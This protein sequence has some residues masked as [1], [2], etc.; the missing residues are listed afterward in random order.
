MSAPILVI[1]FGT[2]TSAASVVE[3]DDAWLVAEPASGGYLWP[4]AVCWDG[5]QLLVGTLADRRK[6]TDPTT[7]W[8][9]FKRGLAVDTP[10][11]LGHRWFRP[12]EL[13]VTVLSALKA[14]AQRQLGGTIDR[15]VLTVP[16][17]YVNGDPRRA[18]MAAAAEAA[19]FVA[20][21]LVPEPAA[22]A[23]AS[24]SG[25]HGGELVLVY[26]LG[27]GTF[28]A[29]L[30]RL[31]ETW[32]E[33]LGHA[34]LDDCGGRDI[35]ALLSSRIRHE[36]DQWLT[37]LR[38]TMAATPSAP[39]ALRLSMAIAD[40]AQRIKHQLTDVPVAQD[41]LMPNT[42][43]YQLARPE[44]AHMTAPHI[45]RTIACCTDLLA[46]L[47]VPLGDVSSVV[48]AGG[49]SRMPV[50][51]ERLERDLG[52][53]LRRIPEPDLAVVRGAA[54]WLQRSGSRVVQA[55]RIPARTVPLAF[56]IPG[57]SARLLRWHVLPGETYAEG[58]RLARVRL[59][60][61]AL[62]DLTAAAPG[63]ID[64]FLVQPGRD[65]GATD[66]LALARH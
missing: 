11:L 30:V 41:F 16:A 37:P 10:I 47:G 50:I 38:N 48:L 3:D 32:H 53:P 26:D 1:D 19:G 28:D 44:F 58:S 13:V 59:P 33:V 42:P 55:A 61:G 25:Q 46:R 18:R 4:S 49:S 34:A 52:R 29:A 62:W 14:E 36:S 51:A 54:R 35:D 43:M 6:R 23:F 20:V 31:G 15:A 5:Q 45:G 63:M 8:A 56:P 22:A 66:W 57:G 39:A 17:S 2:T 64:R 12:S 27:G 40:F 9:E 24:D 65:V 60:S 21:E 7:Y